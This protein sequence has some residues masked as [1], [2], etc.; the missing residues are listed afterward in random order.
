MKK[1][2]YLKFCLLNRKER[3]FRIIIISLREESGLEYQMTHTLGSLPTP[4]DTGVS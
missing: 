2:S 3:F 4:V 1:S